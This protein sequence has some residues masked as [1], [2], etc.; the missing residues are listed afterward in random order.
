VEKTPAPAKLTRLCAHCSRV[1]MI[2][3][4]IGRRHRLC[5]LQE[6]RLASKAASQAHWLNKPENAE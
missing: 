6:C 1:F 3:P 4:R 2:D 5:D